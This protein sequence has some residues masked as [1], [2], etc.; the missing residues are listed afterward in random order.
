MQTHLAGC[1]I[2]LSHIIV[3]HRNTARNADSFRHSPA[4]Y[5]YMQ[6]LNKK[7]NNYGGNVHITNATPYPATVQSAEPC[8]VMM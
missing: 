5:G 7:I 6:T 1:L 8:A 3:T 4:K 2:L